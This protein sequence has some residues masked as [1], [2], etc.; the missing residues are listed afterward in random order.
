MAQAPKQALSSTS[1]A[2]KAAALALTPVSRETLARL[3]R[4]VATL[5]AWQAKLNLIAAQTVPQLWTRHIA[6][7]LQLLELRP[8]ARTWVDL[9]SGGGFPG[10]VVGCAVADRGGACVHLIERN[11]KKVAFLRAAIRAAGAAAIVHHGRIEDFASDLPADVVTARALA[12]LDALLR[13]AYPLLK[14][15]AWGLFPKGQDVE[16]ELAEAAKYWI[17]EID[18]VP[19]KTHPDGRVV[20]VR[21]LSPRPSTAQRPPPQGTSA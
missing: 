14:R 19:S 10:L 11:A 21:S 16:S 17:M 3:D 18:L 8:Q 9:G 4:F 6:D 1:A 12:P 7:S 13:S 5:L 20:M 2:D 15:G